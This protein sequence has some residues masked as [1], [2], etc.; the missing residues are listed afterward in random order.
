MNEVEKKEQEDGK[1]VLGGVMILIWVCAIITGL[2]VLSIGNRDWMVFNIPFVPNIFNLQNIGF[3]LAVPALY[4][5]ELIGLYS[6]KAWAVPLGR[7]AL[8][9]TMV[10]F[11]PVGLIFGLILWKRINDP[12]AK[13]YLNYE[14]TEESAEEKTEEEKKD[15]KEE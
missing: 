1:K 6:Q 5:V 15:S 2:G 8:V 3:S 14:I 10:I 13:R 11:F 7:A 12:V 4:I 9:V